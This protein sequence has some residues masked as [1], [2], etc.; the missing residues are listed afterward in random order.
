MSKETLYRFIVNEIEEQ[1]K[2]GEGFIAAKE[3]VDS[4]PMSVVD[5]KNAI[6]RYLTALVLVILNERGYRSIGDGIF[7]NIETCTLEELRRMHE[8]G[9][10]SAKGVNTAVVNLGEQI[11]QLTMTDLSGKLIERG[12]KYKTIGELIGFIEKLA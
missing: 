11:D 10:A 2:N 6:K 3:I 1:G 4:I 12:E 7:L 5:E 8:R 9:F